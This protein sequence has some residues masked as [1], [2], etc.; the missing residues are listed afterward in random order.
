[1]TSFISIIV[2]VVVVVDRNCISSSSSIGMST[3]SDTGIGTSLFISYYFK[4]MLLQPQQR[5]FG[6]IPQK[7]IYPYELIH[8]LLLP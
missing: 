2:V 6:I 3:G 1:M 8:L 4:K 7:D 5:S